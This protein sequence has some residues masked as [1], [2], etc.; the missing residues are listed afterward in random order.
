VGQALKGAEPGT[1]VAAF[2]DDRTDEDLF[3]A[4]PEGAVSVHS[5][6]KP[7]RALYRVSGPDEVREVLATLLEA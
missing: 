2:G 6:G 4:L 7:S 1:L 3:A 5:G